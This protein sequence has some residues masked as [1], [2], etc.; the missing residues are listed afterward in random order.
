VLS[1]NI[2]AAFGT[3]EFRYR[4][5]LIAWGLRTSTLVHLGHVTGLSGVGPQGSVLAVC[6]VHFTSQQCRHSTCT[7]SSTTRSVLHENNGMLKQ[8]CS[9]L[10]HSEKTVDTLCRMLESTL[11]EFMMRSAHF[12]W[13]SRHRYRP[14]LQPAQE[15]TQAHSTAS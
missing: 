15:R 12:S 6:H 11:Q 1:L 5:W 8:L 9:E 7:S 3:I 13:S 2:S 4:S 10:E 14:W